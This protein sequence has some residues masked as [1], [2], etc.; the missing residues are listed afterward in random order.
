MR[1]APFASGASGR[2]SLGPRASAPRRADSIVP[3]INIV[4]LLL[5]FFMLTATLAP[6]D[7]FD[8]ALPEGQA[9]APAP[10]RTLV[11]A[12][13]PE[14][15]LAHEGARGE[16][17]LSGLRAAYR[18]GDTVLLR[19]DAGLDGAAFARLLADLAVAG[20]DGVTLALRQSGAGAGQ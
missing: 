6:P 9:E 12:I 4:F 19:A 1:A 10:P 13:G 17:A 16:D 7:P 20:I 14:G 8:L 2:N 5:I 15:Q 11:L 3:M 18:P